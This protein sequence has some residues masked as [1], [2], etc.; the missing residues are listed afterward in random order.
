MSTVEDVIVIGA[1]PAGLAAAMQLKRCG[2]SPLVI[3]QGKIG[4]LLLNANLVENYPGF[5][6]G[7]SG[8]RLASLIEKQAQRLGVRVIVDRVTELTH[9][10]GQFQIQTPAHSHSARF[11]VIATG[12]RPRPFTEFAIPP[13]LHAR[14]GYEV[15][16]F[17]GLVDRRVA[18]VGAGDAAFD[19]ALNLSRKN[20]VRILNR[21]AE[22]KCLPLL[23]ERAGAARRIQYFEH[24]RVIGI[25]SS[26]E[27]DL[28]LACDT[29]AGA[30]IIH[31]DIL[32]GALGREPRLDF[33]SPALQAQSADLEAQGL[34]HFAGDV[35][36]GLYRQTA[37]AAGDG[38]LAA[39]KIYNTLKELHA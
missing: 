29:P 25:S 36:R 6:N 1:G 15:W 12:T 33:F 31:A 8:P 4:G 3:E 38:L 22:R 24:F 23:W 10:N 27:R 35:K 32:L 5:P 16:P 39:M 13:E 20:D 9:S 14:V 7:V 18:I 30:Q 11:V 17:L 37:I 28:Q 2:L 34:L 21:S 19:Y 26:P